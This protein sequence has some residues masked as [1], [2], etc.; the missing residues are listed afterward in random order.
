MVDVKISFVAEKRVL[1]KKTQLSLVFTRHRPREIKYMSLGMY[2]DYDEADTIAAIYNAR[3]QQTF[4]ELFGWPWD[5][6]SKN[7]QGKNQ[8]PRT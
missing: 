6:R 4:P 3:L 1:D 5:R 8:Q 7:A 2:Q